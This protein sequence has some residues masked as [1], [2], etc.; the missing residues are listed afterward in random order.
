MEEKKSGIS[1]YAHLSTLTPEEMAQAEESASEV[2]EGGA[3]DGASSV[4]GYMP[5]R[6][7]QDAPEKKRME[8]TEPSFKIAAKPDKKEMFNFMFYHTYLNVMGILALVIGIA[9]IVLLV[10]NLVKGNTENQKIMIFMFAAIVLLFVMNS[11]ITLY[12]KA[13][14]Q[15]ES[16]AKPE[17]TIIYTFSDA[18]FDMARGEDEYMAYKWENIFKVKEDKGGFFMYI[19]KNQAFIIPKADLDGKTE[20]FKSMLKEHVTG[21]CFFMKDAQ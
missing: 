9:A 7:N 18:G 10:Y 5:S 21:K 2:L 19:T 13:K 17:N 12:F 4:S 1:S 3:E 6:N 11:P 20:E 8:H 14:K 15:A 16:V